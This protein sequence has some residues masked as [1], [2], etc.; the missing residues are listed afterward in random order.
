M[1]WFSRTLA[2]ERL[3]LLIAMCGDE[4]VGCVRFDIDG[5]QAEVSIYLDPVRHGQG[6]GRL[7]LSQAMEWMHSEHPS[8]TLFSAEVLAENSASA[9]LFQRCGYILTKQ[10]FEFRRINE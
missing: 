10:R 3:E 4:P 1:S 2:S 9:K 6:W 5:E 7:V 8:V